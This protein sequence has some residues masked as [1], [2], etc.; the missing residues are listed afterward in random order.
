MGRG[1]RRGRRPLPGCHRV[2]GSAER[3]QVEPAQRPPR[4]GPGDRVGHPGH[5]PRRDR[6][7]A[8]VGSQRDRAHRH[9]R[10]QAAGQGRVGP[11]GREVFDPPGA[12]GHRPGGRRD[13]G[14]RCRGGPDRAGRPRRGLRRRGGQGPRGGDQQ[15][16]PRRRED[17]QDVRAV[18]RVDPPRGPVPRLR[19]RHQRQREDRPAHRPG[20]GGRGRHLGRT[21]PAHL[22]GRAEPRPR[23][24]HGTPAAA[25]REGSP[26]QDLLRDPGR[27]GPA[28]VRVLRERRGIGPLQLPALPREPHPRLVRVRRHAA[29][30]RVPRPQC[31]ETAAAQEARRGAGASTRVRPPVDREQDVGR[32]RRSAVSDE[33]HEERHQ[34][35][36]QV[37]DQVGHEGHGEARQ[38]FRC[39]ARCEA[40]AFRSATPDQSAKPASTR[41]AKPTATRRR[42]PASGRSPR[43]S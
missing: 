31:R 9:G 41:S 12:Q 27:R 32:D 7:A 15:V 10:D 43:P 13:P 33:G 23:L 25:D 40:H 24:G 26:A 22:H 1:D 14:D 5:D 38:R 11:G 19:A 39:E 37:D 30:A 28:D 35:G 8:R 2:R 17:R 34:V 42:R 3:R 16:G 21:P 29:S 36:D 18:R 20:P 4:R 6:H